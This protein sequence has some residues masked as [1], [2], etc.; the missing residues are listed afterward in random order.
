[1]QTKPVRKK[2]MVPSC[3][4]H[5]IGLESSQLL[6]FVVPVDKIDPNGYC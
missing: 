1:M 4:M 5:T 2:C 3:R 6:L